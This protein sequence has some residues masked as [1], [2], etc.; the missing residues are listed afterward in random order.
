[1]A[2][3]ITFI[4]SSTASSNL[5]PAAWFNDVNNSVYQGKNPSFVTSTG[6]ANAYTVTLPSSTLAALAAGEQLTFKASFANTSAATLTVVGASSL[7]AVS[8]Y[9]G[10]AALV[11]GEIPINAAITVIYNNSVWNLISATNAASSVFIQGQTYTAYIT[12]GVS[13]AYTLTPSPATTANTENQRFAVEFH[14]ASGASPTLAVSG[15]TAKN[16]KYRD[17]TGASVAV[18]AS[19]IPLGWRSDVIYDGTDWLVMEIPAAYVGIPQNLQSAPYTLA[20]TDNGKHIYM[21]SAGAFTI[22]AN[23]SVAFPI[24]AAVSFYNPSAACT[25]PITTDTL[26]DS[27]SGLTGTRTIAQ[28]G[29]VTILKVTATVWVITGTGIS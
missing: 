25:I 14:V 11:G 20:L 1:M 24:G 29:V 16:L 4:D 5:V 19:T 3:H 9:A 17:S 10:G 2:D 13:T 15:Q 22:P 21:N 6:S 18:A 26:R 12:G 23:A 28:Y 8:I 7:G 27:A